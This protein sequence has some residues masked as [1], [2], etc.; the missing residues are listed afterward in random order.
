M[1]KKLFHSH[2]VPSDDTPAIKGKTWGP[3]SLHQQRERGFLPALRPTER[4]H[5]LVKSAPNLENKSRSSASTSTDNILGNSEGDL[6][7]LLTTNNHNNNHYIHT[8]T[9]YHSISFERVELI[10][11]DDEN[12]MTMSSTTSVMT[13]NSDK[14]SPH[15]QSIDEDEIDSDDNRTV[16]CF[17][18]VGNNSSYRNENKSKTK[19]KLFKLQKNN[20]TELEDKQLLP[21]FEKK[22]KIFP[23]K[24]S[25]D[26]KK[27][28]QFA[29]TEIVAATAEIDTTFYKKLQKSLDAIESYPFEE[30]Y[31]EEEVY[32][33]RPKKVYSKSNDDLSLC[34]DYEWTRST[35][36]FKREY[37]FT[38]YKRKPVTDYFDNGTHVNDSS[39]SE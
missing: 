2:K 10:E 7:K 21:A 24:N 6:D 38:N 29:E 34:G 22:S 5:N 28:I 11:D 14:Y 30:P 12:N 25:S 39:S 16:G 18:F 26:T 19:A 23:R 31:Q 9:D 1:N 3:S 13:Y 20:S 15:D 35:S 27:K 33:S 37:F 8:N 32:S 4:L 36:Q 17:S